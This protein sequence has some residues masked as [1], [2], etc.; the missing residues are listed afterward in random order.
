MNRLTK[1]H[2]FVLDAGDLLRLQHDYR[3]FYVYGP[4]IQYSSSR[5]EGGRDGEPTYADLMVATDGMGQL[6]GYLASDES[7]KFLKQL[8]TDN[9]IVPLVGNFCRTAG[10]SRGR[11][12]SE[13]ENGDRLRV[14]RV[15]RGGIPP[16]GRR[17]PGVLRQRRLAAARRGQ[18]L[19]SLGSRP[20]AGR[21]V[22]AEF[23]ADAH[24]PD[25]QR[26]SARTEPSRGYSDSYPITR[27]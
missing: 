16:A 3:A 9:L 1:K 23:S 14:L 10:D 27:R 26:L 8:E 4:K 6:R 18:H 20:D 22:H 21:R 17:A 25:G 19:H 5:N 13:G 2:G 11:S 24:R 15:E 7:F 12:V